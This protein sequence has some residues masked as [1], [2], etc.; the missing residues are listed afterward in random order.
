MTLASKK[1]WSQ[2]KRLPIAIS[3]TNKASK[4]SNK[5]IEVGVAACLPKDMGHPGQPT[6]FMASRE[7]RE[8]A[9]EQVQ[10]P[11]I[12]KIYPDER[13]TW[14]KPLLRGRTSTGA[15]GC[16]Q[17][18]DPNKPTSFSFQFYNVSADSK[19]L[20][21]MNSMQTYLGR[22]WKS[23]SR[24]VFMQSYLSEVLRPKGWL[25]WNDDFALDTLF[26][27]DYQNSGAGATMEKRVKWRGYRAL[28]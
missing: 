18:K 8:M 15:K 12:E 22:L 20:P 25:E 13:H 5:S 11:K 21:L 26:Y 10:R 23:Y 16:A 28:N 19:L 7:K 4:R 24:R 17:C 27:D 14:Q 3:N 6:M 2:Q 9:L 1:V